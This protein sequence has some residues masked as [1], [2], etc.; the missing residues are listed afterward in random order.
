MEESVIELIK[1]NPKI[2]KIEMVEK[3]G[4]SKPTIERMLIKNN[5][6]A[7]LGSNRGGAWI[8]KE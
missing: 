6:I 3:T 8:I 5:K 7:R 2:T 4:K 1:I